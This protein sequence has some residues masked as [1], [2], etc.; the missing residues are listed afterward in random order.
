ME[1]EVANRKQ[2]R[3]KITRQGMKRFIFP[4]YFQ[5]QWPV[6]FESMS[7]SFD[8]SVMPVGVGDE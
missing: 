6:K 1:E 4:F 5:S 8:T 3:E 7:V 2:R